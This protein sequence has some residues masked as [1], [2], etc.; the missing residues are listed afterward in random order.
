MGTIVVPKF[1]A[2]YDKSK[3]P[4]DKMQARIDE[5]LVAYCDLINSIDTTLS[6]GRMAFQLVTKRLRNYTLMDML[7]KGL[8]TYKTSTLQAQS[9]T[10]EL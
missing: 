9:S 5:N 3:P 1:G 10:A 7:T 4:D 8:Q 6:G 2:D